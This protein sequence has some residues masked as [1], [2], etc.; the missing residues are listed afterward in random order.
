MK[1]INHNSG[2]TYTEEP[3]PAFRTELVY[4]R[5]KRDRTF[6]PSKV[7]PTGDFLIECD[8]CGVVY[9]G[10]DPREA[11]AAIE[12]HNRAEGGR[13][14]AGCGNPHPYKL[15]AHYKR[16]RELLV[17]GQFRVIR[18]RAKGTPLIVPGRDDSDNL[19][20]FLGAA[21]GFRGG[22]SYATAGDIDILAEASAANNCE[23][24]LEI[25]AVLSPG[26]E[27]VVHRF[28]RRLNEYDEYTW[29]GNKLVSKTYTADEWA[30]KEEIGQ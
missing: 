14:Y 11:A 19:L 16:R 10:D 12:T 17:D 7:V 13:I 22:V 9:H 4:G 29:D 8:A 21:G 18:T 26:A 30:V 15:P 23:S 6:V 1:F 5:R 2:F 25:A 3:F 28:G 24:G 20:L 27:I